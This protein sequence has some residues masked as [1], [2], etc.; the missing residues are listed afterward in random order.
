MK[1]LRVVLW[2]VVL[3]LSG[4]AAFGFA[5]QSSLTDQD[6][7][8]ADMQN[9]ITNPTVQAE[10]Q[11][12][13]RSATEAALTDLTSQGGISGSLIGS[14]DPNTLADAASS[15]VDTPAF[16]SAWSSWAALLGQG[17]ADSALGIP[18]DD[19]TV[20]GEIVDVRI[21]PLVAPLVANSPLSE[22]SGVAAGLFGDRTLSINSGED[23]EASLS[24]LGSA[25]EAR[26]YVLAVAI[27]VVVALVVFVPPRLGSL[28]GALA[29]AAIGVA[30]AAVALLLGG[31]SGGQSPT[32]A[33]SSAISEAFTGGNI[34]PLLLVALLLAVI[35]MGVAVIARRSARTTPAG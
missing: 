12:Q 8:V 26:W 29:G 5:A 31:Q 33:L 9:A 14:I 24:R 7:F 4:F 18:N 1:I 28:A 2:G 20:Q 23:L 22:F 34:W 6:A 27:L 11:A 15:A 3:L 25:A 16:Q 10:V 19:V 13:I 35:A 17:L 32:P 21:G 30:L